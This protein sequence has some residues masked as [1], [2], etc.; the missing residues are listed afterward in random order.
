MASAGQHGYVFKDSGTT[1]PAVAEETSMPWD[2]QKPIP[3]SAD[4]CHTSSTRQNVAFHANQT[5]PSPTSAPQTFTA[6]HMRL[7]HLG[8]VKSTKA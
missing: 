6:S 7:P 2:H 1:L 5:V 4:Q 8:W 3:S